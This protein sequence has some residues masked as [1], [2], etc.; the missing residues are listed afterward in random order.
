MADFQN[1]ESLTTAPPPPPE[2]KVRTMRSDLESMAK[3]GGGLPRFQNVKVGAFS[4]QRRQDVDA[5]AI[6]NAPGGSAKKT[7]ALEIAAI[8]ILALFIV[9]ALGYFAYRFFVK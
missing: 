8:T 1:N 2:V 5:A 7:N 4:A 9:G 6:A 3:S